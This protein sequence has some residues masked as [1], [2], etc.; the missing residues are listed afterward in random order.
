M[1]LRIPFHFHPQLFHLEYPH[2]QLKVGLIILI[3][4]PVIFLVTT[5]RKLIPIEH[6]F[7]TE[8]LPIILKSYFTAVAKST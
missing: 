5:V 2:L 4:M 3:R 7:F 8:E 1:V 6:L